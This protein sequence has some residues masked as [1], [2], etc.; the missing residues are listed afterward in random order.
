MQSTPCKKDTVIQFLE[1]NGNFKSFI[2]GGIAGIHY[3]LGGV[4]FLI[5]RNDV[6]VEFYYPAPYNPMLD[7]S[8]VESFFFECRPILSKM[9][10]DAADKRSISKK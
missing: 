1:A 6:S 9:V 7:Y 8:P 5:Y 10:R 4:D 2:D 3:R